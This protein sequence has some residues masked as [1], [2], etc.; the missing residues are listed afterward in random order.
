MAEVRHAN[1]ATPRS[2]TRHATTVVLAL[3]VAAACC[4]ARSEQPATTHT[5]HWSYDEHTGPAKWGTLDPCFTSCSIGRMQSP[6]DL[7][8]AK[9][10]GL[11]PI[12]FHYRPAALHI[13][14]NGHTVQVN[15]EKG[16]CIEVEG[17]RRD[18]VQ[19][20]F[21]APSEHAVRGRQYAAELHLVH[22]ND[23][24]QFSVVGV[25]IDEGTTNPAYEPVWDHMPAEVGAET[26]APVTVDAGAL[27]PKVRTTYR[28]RGSLTT[29]PCTEGV[30]W[31]VM[32]QPVQLSPKQID[33][34]RR[35]FSGNVRP[36]QPVNARDVFTDIEAGL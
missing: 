22:K 33:A 10:R 29:P 7:H 34:F 4:H 32:T 9:P 21:H 36:V 17:V 15:Y 26:S 14:N 18:L 20:H 31:F 27:L 30:E 35:L 19:F 25:L 16:S 8:D 11:P 1:A 5:T 28:Y 13:V 3:L 6:I 23:R 24:G 12:V 2:A